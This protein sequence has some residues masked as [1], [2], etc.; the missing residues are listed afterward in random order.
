MAVQMTINSLFVVVPAGFFLSRPPIP[1]LAALTSLFA[2]IGFLERAVGARQMFAPEARGLSPAQA[3]REKTGLRAFN[4][5]LLA[6][7]G[8]ALVAG[9]V[10]AIGAFATAVAVAALATTALATDRGVK[11]RR[12]KR[13]R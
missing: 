2:L 1:V 6:V 13:Q 10:T 5:A 4:Y 8:S 3:E 11:N 7:S 12:R 9:A